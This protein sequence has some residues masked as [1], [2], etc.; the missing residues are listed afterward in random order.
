MMLTLAL[1]QQLQSPWFL[2]SGPMESK[3]EFALAGGSIW[4]AAI[5]DVDGGCGRELIRCQRDADRIGLPAVQHDRAVAVAQKQAGCLW[6]GQRRARNRYER[7]D[8]GIVAGRQGDQNIVGNV[9]ELLVLGGTFTN[10][11]TRRRGRSGM[12]AGNIPNSKR[13]QPNR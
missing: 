12:I 3:D 5:G 10:F 2:Q 11:G 6:T 8:I 7:V 9:T 1:V 13:E 4:S